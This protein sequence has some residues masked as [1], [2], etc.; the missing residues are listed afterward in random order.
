MMVPWSPEERKEEEACPM[1]WVLLKRGVC[2]YLNKDV[3][4][5]TK[6]RSNFTTENE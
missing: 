5:S 2:Y 4:L 6:T 3:S 1:L